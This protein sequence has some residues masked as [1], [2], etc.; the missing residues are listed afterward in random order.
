MIPTAPRYFS[1]SFPATQR[2]S[3]QQPDQNTIWHRKF[4]DC[5]GESVRSKA[6]W[7]VDHASSGCVID[8]RI[9]GFSANQFTA[10]NAN[11]GSVPGSI[12]FS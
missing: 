2:A 11:S 12:A 6:P 9:I 7:I 8:N 5:A 4:P 1:E 10:A 3:I